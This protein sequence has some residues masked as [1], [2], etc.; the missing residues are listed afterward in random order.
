MRS[1]SNT[2]ALIKNSRGIYCLDTSM[3]CE[4]GLKQDVR[5]CYGDCYAAKS[6][7]I[8][9]YDFGKTI[10]RHFQGEHHKR[11]IIN[12]INNVKL[13]FIRIGCS[14][15]PSENWE[16]CLKIISD[17]KW[18]NKQIVIITK[19]WQNLSDNQ[20]EFLSTL[21]ICINTSV[22]AL[23][24]PELLEN[25][26]GQYHRIKKYCKSIIRIVSCDFNLENE[27]GLRLSLLQKELFKNEDCIDTIFRPNKNNTL[28]TSGIVNVKT[29]MFNGS[30]TLMSKYNKK[31][32][33]GKCDKCKEMCGVNIDNSN[34]I[35]VKDKQ[36]IK[37]INIFNK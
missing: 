11:K 34:Y 37:Q 26:L 18:V 2:I 22:S 31:T 5:G 36:I 10:L 33:S 12:Q 3:G 24:K 16:H 23:D 17:I 25:S 8:Y 30:K 29:G 15:D 1:Y 28:V 32:Y 20:L 7:K 19:H 21:N 27:T 13:D 9:G 6:A 4:S 14:G 35:Y